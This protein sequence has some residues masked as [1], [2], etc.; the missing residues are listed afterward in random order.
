[1]SF[2]CWAMRMSTL[3]S[4]R[5]S[6]WVGEASKATTLTWSF[7]PDC[8]TPVPAPCPEKT[9]A[10][11]MPFRS[12]F[13]CRVEVVME[14]AW[15]G[16]S[17][18]YSVPRYSMFGYSFIASSK[19]SFL[20]SVVEMPGLTLMTRT[21]PSSPICLARAS[22]ACLPPSSLSEEILASAISSFSMVVS[23]S[24]T[25]MSWLTAFCIGATIEDVRHR[26]QLRRHGEILINRLDPPLAGVVRRD[27]LHP[28]PLEDDLARMDLEIHVFES[29]HRAEGL[30]YPPGLQHGPVAAHLP[31][32]LAGAPYSIKHPDV[33]GA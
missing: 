30:V 2:G 24:T 28:L 9:L 5:S 17:L 31:H 27:E 15:V 10:P 8:R 23:T 18:Q 16:S 26:V 7:L 20:W 12:E 3:P 14:A 25:A 1:M 4:R 6:T 33:P 29:T 21:L 22:P 11:K 19:P 13:D 32:L